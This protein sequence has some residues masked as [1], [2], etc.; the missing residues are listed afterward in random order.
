MAAPTSVYDP[1]SELFVANFERPPNLEEVNLRALTPFQRALLVIDGTVTK[2]IE[3]VT[4]EQVE[5]QLIDQATQRLK[6]EHRLL[7]V[8]S[9]TPVINRRVLLLGKY[10]RTLHAYA[11]SVVVPER[12]IPDFNKK[13]EI[14]GESLGRM[15]LES[16]MEQYREL[17][18]CGRE[19]LAD[20]PDAIK[21]HAGKSFL[22]RTY[23]ISTEK[24]PVMLINEKFPLETSPTPFHH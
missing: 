3:A 16:R 17:L 20:P 15:L 5:V 18:W 6:T 19:R 24:R 14:P 4:M 7:E 11:S 23:R 8:L 22:S 12:A 21:E 1:I 2:F 9:Q 10:S 13:L